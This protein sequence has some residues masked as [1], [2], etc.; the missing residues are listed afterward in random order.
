MTIPCPN[1]SFDERSV[2]RDMIVAVLSQARTGMRDARLFLTVLF[3]IG[4]LVAAA[5]AGAAEDTSSLP[6]GR[7]QE[8][9]VLRQVAIALAAGRDAMQELRGPR[10]RIRTWT[11]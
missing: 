5:S 2:R 9:N 11:G 3:L 6:S 1:H 8:V 7:S 4:T 10:L